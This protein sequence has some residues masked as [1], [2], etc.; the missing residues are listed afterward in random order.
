MNPKNTWM[1]VLLA[2]GLFAFIYFFERHIQPPPP[3]VARVLPTLNADE[4]TS[5][6]ILP[7]D[8]FAIRVE[9]INGVWQLTKPLAY[10]VSVPEVENFLKSLEELAPQRR[11]SMGELQN[12]RNIGTNFGFD[13]PQATIFIQQG[14]DQ[15][16]LELGD[17]TA[18]GDGVYVRVV[19]VDGIDIISTAF[20]ASVPTNAVSWRDTSFVNLQG[21]PFVE[22]DVTDAGGQLK[23][24]RD[25]PGKP[26][27]IISPIQARADNETINHLL[28]Q[29]QNLGV[30]QFVRDD[31]NADLESYGLEPAQLVL[32]FRDK[33]TNQLL[34]LQFGKSA[35]SDTN[36][37]YA[38][39]N[40]SSTIVAVPR[41]D[42]SLWSAGSS[43][44]RDPHLYSLAISDQ[45]GALE[46]YG[47]DGRT[48]FIVKM[49]NGTLMV[50][51]GEG[52]GFPAETNVVLAAIR[53]LVEMKVAPWSADR[54]ADDAV[55][56]PDLAGMGLSPNP[57][58]RYVLRAAPEAG[59]ASRMLAQLDF[60]SP[61]TNNPGTICARRSDL[62]EDLSVYAINDTDFNL[63]PSLAVQLRRHRIWDFDATMVTNLQIQA[64]GQTRTWE[65]TKKYVWLP[66]PVGVTDQNKG[67][68]MENLADNLGLLE[69][70][71]W[72][73]PGEPTAEYGFTGN[74]LKISL[75]VTK[76]G[77]SANLTVTIGGPVT[78]GRGA[79][80]ACT[81]M[82]NGQNWIFVL[83]AKD[84]DELV[85]YLPTDN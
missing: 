50:V 78:G 13:R 34:S 81:P 9:R 37:V 51:N 73:G 83:S 75:T 18:P 30:R 16:Q 3:V 72:V 14:D 82:D 52:Q 32:T 17:V 80:F 65:H 7:R 38:R 36:L 59:D 41:D 35:A 31:T 29:L 84:M 64:N 69:A 27:G 46:C 43:R 66:V 8:Q 12:N 33:N 2:G 76:E 26:W 19:G 57:L 58:R 54:F 6:E 47:P 70:L 15:R 20:A 10:P 79:C 11:I 63:L 21:L 48:N 23:F 74:S 67:M 77:Q 5:I 71:A 62:S 42:L 28:D 40:S 45:P 85:T 60:G 56:E 49:L 24:H 68:Y 25:D 1:L 39:T 22:L 61:N 4:V 53:D 55:A 44:F